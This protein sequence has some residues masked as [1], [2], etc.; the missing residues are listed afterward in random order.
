MVADGGVLSR[1]EARQRVVGRIVNPLLLAVCEP[2]AGP[3]AF[4]NA[5]R[6]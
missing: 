6:G 5:R 4:A 3:R 2:P 1:A